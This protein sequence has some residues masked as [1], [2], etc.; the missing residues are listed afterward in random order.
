MRPLPINKSRELCALMAAE[1][2]NSA[3]DRMARLLEVSTSGFHKH[4]GRS[5]STRWD[6]CKQRRADLKVKISDLYK[7]SNGV[8]GSPRITAELHD[9]GDVISEKRSRRSC[10]RSAS[11]V[12]A[13][14]QGRTLEESSRL[15]DRRSL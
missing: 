14:D 5:G 1:C 2:A 8:Y 9:R 13:R 12:S 6:E 11:S 3:I 10:A 4:Q 15:V 7:E